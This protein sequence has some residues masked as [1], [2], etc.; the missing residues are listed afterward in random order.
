[1]PEDKARKRAVRARMAETGENYTAA[2]RKLG[3]PPPMRSDRTWLNPPRCDDPYEDII[4]NLTPAAAAAWSAGGQAA[5][6]EVLEHAR[7]AIETAAGT[8][9]PPASGPRAA[10]FDPAPP[11]TAAGL[12]RRKKLGLPPA[13][14]V[15]EP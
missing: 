8:S 14:G 9:Y 12:A 5:K 3:G 2:A 1:M 7:W 15:S 11:A 13:G 6:D 10:W 4:V